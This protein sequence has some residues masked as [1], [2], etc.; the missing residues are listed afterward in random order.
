MKPATFTYN[1]T[2]RIVK[3]H[4]RFYPKGTY[5]ARL[6]AGHDPVGYIERCIEEDKKTRLSRIADYLAERAARPTPVVE[7]TNQLDLF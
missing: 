6:G 3:R 4:N 1:P 7:P 2:S 5:A